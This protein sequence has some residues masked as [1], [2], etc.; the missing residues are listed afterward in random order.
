MP[1]GNKLIIHSLVIAVTGLALL[2]SRFIAQAQTVAPLTAVRVASGLSAPVF[3]TAPPADPSRLFIVEQTGGV[4]ILNLQTLTLDA[5]PFVDLSPLL[6]NG[7][8]GEQGLLG[9]AFHPDYASNGKFYTYYTAPGGVFGE[10]VSTVSQI[11]VTASP[12]SFTATPLL[13]F[14]QPQSNHNGGWIGFSPRSGDANNLYI[15]TGDGG[16]GNDEG[17]GRI[18]PGGN[19]QNN[20]TLLGQIL[21][22]NVDAAAGTYSIPANNPFAGAAAPVRREIWTLGL[23]NPFRCGFDRTTGD[24]FIGDVGQGAREEGR[25]KSN[26]SRRRGELRLALA[27]GDNP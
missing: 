10:G 22:I 13:S 9:L 17:P 18:E 5:T 26:Q 27:R 14:D 20:T 15:A 6:R 21:R 16:N 12:N 11:Q 3:I 4:R 24:F 7:R 19:S 2:G 1:H 8:G 23:R 25:A